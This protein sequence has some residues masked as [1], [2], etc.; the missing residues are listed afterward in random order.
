MES[1]KPNQCASGISNGHAPQATVAS[2]R[3]SN[4]TVIVDMVNIVLHRA[5]HGKNKVKDG[6]EFE[7]DSLMVKTVSKSQGVYNYL[8]EYYICLHYCLISGN[9]YFLDLNH[10]IF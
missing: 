10:I 9:R 1:G 4:E 6:F 2:G 3:L 8:G 5:H 7:G